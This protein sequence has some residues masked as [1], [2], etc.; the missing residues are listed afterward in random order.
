MR[1]VFMALLLVPGLSLTGAVQAQQTHNQNENAHVLQE[2]FGFKGLDEA[3]V[4]G[5]V[6][7]NTTVQKTSGGVVNNIS[8][9]IHNVDGGYSFHVQETPTGDTVYG[10]SLIAHGVGGQKPGNQDRGGHD[11]GAAGS[12]P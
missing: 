9:S 3:G 5:H 4:Q 12:R 6:N 10:G 7:N 2:H 1:P 11:G 8:N